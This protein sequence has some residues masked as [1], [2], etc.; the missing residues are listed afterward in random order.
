MN[1]RITLLFLI[2]LSILFGDCV[3]KPFQYIHVTGTVLDYFTHEP[4]QGLSLYLTSTYGGA[5]SN[6][7][8]IGRR[9]TN[10]KGKFEI[11]SRAS[12]HNEYKLMATYNPSAL[13]PF[14]REVLAEKISLNENVGAILNYLRKEDLGVFEAGPHQFVI[15]INVIPV[16]T[17]STIKIYGSDGSDDGVH[18]I[19]PNSGASFERT[20]S[21][22]KSQLESCHRQY[23]VSY[24]ITNFNGTTNYQV[25]VPIT[26]SD[27]LEVNL[28]Y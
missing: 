8:T 22:L 13:F 3:K 18:T 9:T 1:K 25:N 21:Y 23:R 28:E 2:V 20:F 11:K 24:S 4:K 7:Q 26:T 27:Q 5:E 15:K 10:S 6:I 16:S 19:G 12:V 14:D 17:Y